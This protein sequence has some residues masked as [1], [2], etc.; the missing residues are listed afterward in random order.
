ML[1]V[2]CIHS[3]RGF[4]QNRLLDGQAWKVMRLIAIFLFAACM[5]VCAKGYTQTVSLQERNATLESVFQ[6]LKKQ[7]GLPVLYTRSM[8]KDSKRVTVNLKNVP[9]QDALDEILKDQ[10]L[11]YSI[12]N[13]TVVIKLKE[14]TIQ[15]E[16]V[17]EP[18]TINT[19]DISGRITDKEGNPLVNASISVK[20]RK[21]GATTNDNGMFLL[22]G[23]T[24]NDVIVISFTGYKQ[25]TFKIGS[26]TNFI[27]SLELDE[28]PLNEI[29]IKPYWTE[30]K[31][32]EV[33]NTGRITAKDIERQPVNNPL[34]ALQG[35]VAGLNIVQ[36]NGIP[37]GAVTVRIQG[38]NNLNQNIV[39]SDPLIVIDGVPYMSQN[40]TTF[41]GGTDASRSILG[42]SGDGGSSSG[43]FGNPL[44]FINPNDIES[45]D[46]LKDADAT[47]IYGSRAANGALLITTK[48]G[49]RGPMQVNVNFQQAFG[50]VGHKM[51]LL[52]SQ[53]YMEMRR[54]AKR[55][56]NAAILL[57]DYD[58]R[59][60][61][62]T[63]RNTDWQKELIG[64][65]A[66]ITNLTAGV[67][68]GDQFFQYLISGT[69]AK[70]TSVF[71]GNF[72]NIRASF[73]YNLTA[74]DKTNRFR[75]Q[76]GG[77]YM[78]NDNKLP[79]FDYTDAALN[80]P[81]VAPPLFNSD[82]TLHWAPD[83]LANGNSSWFNPLARQYDQFDTKT[84]NLFTSMNISYKV[85]P[86]LEIRSNFGFT[87]TLS[88][89]FSGALNASVKPETVPG[90]L[91]SARFANS[92]ASSW[93]VEPQLSYGVNLGKGK[94]DVTLG[95]T[96]QHQKSEGKG[97]SISGQPSDQLL[98]NLASAVS[99]STSGLDISMYRY[100][101]VFAR[102]GYN[103][104][105]RYLISLTGRRDGSSRFGANNQ[106][107]NFGAAGLGW[108][109]SE[110]RFFRSLSKV[111][112][113]LKL[114]GSYGTTGSD[115]L[116]NY[117]F[118]DLY[119]A[120]IPGIP[121][122]GVSTL[123]PSA[124][125]NP[126]LQWES[127]RKLQG[128]VDMTFLNSRLQL[129]VTYIQNRVSNS[130]TTVQLPL[131]TGFFSVDLNLPALVQNTGWEF[132]FSSENFK[133]SVFT[134]NTRA[135]LTIPRN[136]LVSFPD[137]DKS[138]L[139][140]QLVVGR[141]LDVFR[142]TPYYGVDPLTGIYMVRDRHGNPTNST[143]LA[144]D[145]RF[146]EPGSRLFG[147]ISNNFSY[148]GFELD[149]FIQVNKQYRLATVVTQFSNPGRFLST[150]TPTGNQPIE[151]LQ[152]WQ[153]PGDITTY[154]RYTSV[155]GSWLG[156]TGDRN[157][158]DVSFARLK[159]VAISYRFSPELLK[160]LSMQQLR[161]YVNAQ[162]L[163]TL[164]KYRGL[165][166]ESISTSSLPP[167]RVISL[168]VQGVF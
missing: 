134:W 72:A 37:G 87:S 119:V 167:L 77:S 159:T 78:H 143:V 16:V 151:V 117:R 131:L 48:R 89:Q 50:N 44:A 61:W 34:L 153:K 157:W 161:V 96:F 70:E 140:N 8:L 156:L 5:Q 135:N 60:L 144:D 69:Y 6:Q 126:N 67:S 109:I 74:S 55:N 99:L 58:L 79:G 29:I 158:Q 38:R 4:N 111:V 104:K 102:I 28:N 17:S 84:G 141:S 54:E 138:T 2:L 33:G 165:D 136:K 103:Y 91:R 20:G 9:L 166:P 47:A 94:L 42:R 152:R 123:N 12:I 64:G 40:L 75:I 43:S 59:G 116:G 133:N 81:P 15:K 83:P 80:T 112:N 100:S 45:I 92:K 31:R 168:G 57:T 163:F 66:N 32:Y 88:D 35:R 30:K 146:L 142:T 128:G 10:G 7:T 21:E 155:N 148:K 62:D 130:L 13:N 106:V 118:M 27:V 154:Q 90:R 86:G 113:F 1:K 108:I 164:T 76:F 71:P 46:V 36:A 127:N 85:L 97:F 114:R 23:L 73:H 107:E 132:V 149:V 82:G 14:N 150:T 110:E 49:K 147:G 26:Q 162:N 121:Y 41:L 65:T 52:N 68:G 22:K 122:Q 24:A 115:Q 124:L 93:I 98:R 160:K 101:G 129:S 105:E 125:P 139:R 51:K 56:D 19:I 25:Q 3:P 95:S 120:G 145:T 53:Q 63:T 39:G 18:V 11:G 137:L